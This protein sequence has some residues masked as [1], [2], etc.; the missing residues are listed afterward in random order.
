VLGEFADLRR[1]R[2]LSMVD[3]PQSPRTIESVNPGIASCT[4][5]MRVAEL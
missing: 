5:A 2:S 4:S 1:S 3:L